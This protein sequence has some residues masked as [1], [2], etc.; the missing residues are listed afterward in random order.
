[1]RAITVILV[2]SDQ[3]AKI[4]SGDVVAVTGIVSLSGL[5]YHL[6]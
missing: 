4:F 5:I 3:W 1:M 2:G 6:N